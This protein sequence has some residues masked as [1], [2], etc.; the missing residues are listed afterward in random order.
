MSWE[1][2]APCKGQTDLFYTAYH[3]RAA[4]LCKTCT[5][6]PECLAAAVE[7]ERGV[8]WTTFGYRAGMTARQ[9][10]IYAREHHAVVRLRAPEAACGTDSGYK[11]HNR[12]GTTPCEACLAAH[13]AAERNQRHPLDLGQ[14]RC[15]HY[16][17][18]DMN[19]IAMRRDLLDDD[20][21][22]DAA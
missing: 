3:R 8:A 4:E 22:T 20:E 14:I 18:Y 16:A 9:R 17:N 6:K 1:D 21:G 5:V 13:A 19:R 2:D 10:L 11:R 7:E 15:D 12:T